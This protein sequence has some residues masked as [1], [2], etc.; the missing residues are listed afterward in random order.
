MKKLIS[1]LLALAMMLG[2]IAFAEGVN[3]TGT[4]VLTGIEADGIQMGMSMLSM[5]GMDM[6][7]ILNED[8][9]LVLTSMGIDENG[10][11]AV[12][13]NG[14]AIT[15]DTETLEVAYQDE[16]LAMDEGGTLMMFTREGAAPAVVEATGPVACANVPAE[17]FEGQWL[18]TRLDMLG[19]TLPAEDFDMYMAF[20]LS[21][22]AGIY[23]TNDTVDGSIVTENVTY[24]LAEVEGVGTVLT[25]SFVEVA[26]GVEEEPLVLK[27]SDAGELYVEEAGIYMY[28]TKQIEEPAAE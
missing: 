20:V 21:D 14:I 13:E 23:G 1:L 4:W 6:T 16:I 26:E 9:T 2:C 7:L 24:E 8:G 18:L 28:F 3:Y 11:W 15:D 19:L 22:G 25:V 12:T 10:T 17:A 27:M 5:M